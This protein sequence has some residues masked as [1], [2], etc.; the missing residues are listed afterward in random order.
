ML[1]SIPAIMSAVA[2]DIRSPIVGNAWA[3]TR[4]AGSGALGAEIKV[5][6]ASPRKKTFS[7][8][9]PAR[10]SDQESACA[11]ECSGAEQSQLYQS[12]SNQPRNPGQRN[13]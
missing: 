2:A 9:V 6:L 3:G 13:S 8:L 5:G 4:N 12:N 7:F 11:H 10:Q 1:G